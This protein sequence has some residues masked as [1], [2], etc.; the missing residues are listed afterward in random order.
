VGPAGKV[1]DRALMQ[2][3]ISRSSVY[4]TNAVKHFRWKADGKRRLHDRPRPGDVRACRAWLDAE[5]RA[6]RPHV[7]VCLGATAAQSFL[8]SRFSV[9]RYRGQ[10]FDTP[11]AKDF[12]VTYHPAAILRLPD[13]AASA[14]AFGDLVEHLVAAR[15]RL[16]HQESAMNG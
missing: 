13:P 3:G 4:L 5:I 1:L 15:E 7:I 16:Q 14:R 2:A 11:W 6:V 12:V 8:G 9:T 10:W